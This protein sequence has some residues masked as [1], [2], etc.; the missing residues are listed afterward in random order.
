MSGAAHE[1]GAGYAIDLQNGMSVFA[2]GWLCSLSGEFYD[3]ASCTVYYTEPVS[4]ESIYRVEIYGSAPSYQPEPEPYVEPEPEPYV[5]PA[6]VS[7]SIDGTA[8]RD[9][10]R[11]AV[12]FLS[13]GDTVY[14]DIDICNQIGELVMA[15][16]G[17]RCTVYYYD[18]PSAD[19]IYSVDV[20]PAE[21][22]GL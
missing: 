20:Y 5:E 15:G 13:N 21:D 6:P 3:G 18:Y 19:N 10:D 1:G 11:T 17:N 16:A 12:L 2:D 14:V 4:N 22:S 8:F 7:G 9:S